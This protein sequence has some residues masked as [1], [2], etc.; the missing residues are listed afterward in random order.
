MS[1]T[2]RMARQ[3]TDLS[4]HSLS[5]NSGNA[6]LTPSTLNVHSTKVTS[7]IETE[8]GKSSSPLSPTESR[9]PRPSP[10][11]L[12]RSASLRL[13]GE[14]GAHLRSPIVSSTIHNYQIRN[15]SNHL[16]NYHQSQANAQDF[17]PIIN[18]N[19]SDS[20]RHRSSS[21]SL[22]PARPRPIHTTS[23][24]IVGFDDSDVESVKS[25]GSACSTASACD[26]ASFALNGT[27]WSGRSRKYVVHC[28]NHSGDTEQYL[29]PTQRAARQIRKFQIL[30]KEARK[31]IEEKN[32]EIVRLTKEVVELRLYKASLN[33]P[34][35]K[36]D[37]SDAPT[38]RENDPLS[39]QSPT[40][41]LPDEGR[42]E[43]NASP[44]SPEI[45]VSSEVP[46]SLAD[47]GHFEDSSI[48]L[49]EAG[50]LTEAAVVNNNNNTITSTISNIA[51]HENSPNSTFNSIVEIPDW[52]EERRKL[53]DHYESRIEEL[54]R[55]H[56]DDLQELKEKHNDK[57]ESL[58]NQLAEI[59][60]RY[61]EIRPSLDTA[62]VR[63]RELETE[64]ETLKSELMEQKALLSDQEERN[65]QMYLKMFA[66]G[67]EAARIEQTDQILEHAHE[68]PPKVTVAEL[69]QQLTV[70]QAELEN[71][72]AMYRR[73]VESRN[74]QAVLDPE[75]TLQFLK[76]AIYYFLTD[77]ENHQGHLNAIES[78]LGF[79]ANE[80][81]NIDKI[82]RSVRK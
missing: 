18:E 22:T 42:F 4:L 44:T 16:H 1:W 35:E 71:I 31:E 14:R 5:M 9:I 3:G 12:R 33:S 74:T 34:E 43:A 32:Q 70:T 36:T 56:I 29:T 72:K 63:V 38:I 76:S 49:K 41:D 39:P 58:L 53:V 15:N 81:S 57:V 13:R 80:K 62:E 48:H 59:N 67:Q 26:H 51:Q 20:P 82:Y 79:S 6:A 37:S 28:S 17:F 21:L 50:F 78:I 27:T 46:S 7:G 52:D 2:S 75:I 45:Q 68:T 11:A 8:T 55:R 25:Y 61:C 54:H 66:K 60:K 77:K 40:R 10:T 47:S 73:I 69:L 24:C 23:S 19:G 64:L 65:K 30:L